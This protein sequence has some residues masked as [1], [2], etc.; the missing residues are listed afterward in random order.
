VVAP[1]VV[2]VWLYLAWAVSRRRDPARIAVA[3]FFGLI[4]MS[5]L[6][7]LSAGAPLYTPAVFGLGAAQWFIALVSLVL[8]FTPASNRFFRSA[9]PVPAG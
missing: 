8:V 7:A 2:A 6:A 9:E 4:T 3:A 1:L 5:L